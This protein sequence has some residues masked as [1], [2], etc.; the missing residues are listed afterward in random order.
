M[1]IV[2]GNS[3]SAFQTSTPP[4]TAWC[5][6]SESSAPLSRPMPRPD[7]G[8]AARRRRSRTYAC[9]DDSVLRKA[10]SA[11]AARSILRNTGIPACL[12]HPAERVV[13]PPGIDHHHHR[14]RAGA[15]DLQ[16][17]GGPSEPLGVEILAVRAVGDGRQGLER[18]RDGHRRQDRG[19]DAGAGEDGRR[20][21]RVGRRRRHRRRV[22][23]IVAVREAPAAPSSSTARVA[24]SNVA[25]CRSP[26][27]SITVE[28]SKPALL[29]MPTRGPRVALSDSRV[30]VLSRSSNSS[31]VSATTTPAASRQPRAI[32]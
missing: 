27:A 24:A 18:R 12:E 4:A 3:P 30:K 8:H 22:D 21:A 25:S 11:R 20:R 13:Q 15:H 7:H 32:A 10:A 1:S 6:V 2:S 26:S 9:P 28:H 14:F 29:R 31:S 17:T 19:V 5:S 16:P 23:R